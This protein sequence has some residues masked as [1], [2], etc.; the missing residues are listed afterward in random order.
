MNRTK[1]LVLA[2]FA[3]YWVFVVVLLVAARDFYDSQLPQTLRLPG[4]NQRPAEIGTLLV[5]TALFAVLSI[6]VIR[7]W[8]WTFWLILIVFLVNI[9]RVPAAALQLAGI[10]SS[11]GPAWDTVLQAV[12]GLIQF[13]I[14]LAMLAGYRKA[15]VWGAF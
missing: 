7:G 2:L 14:A 5:A 12:V 6:G 10:A 3:G 11:Q 15:G 13:A 8:R 1:V 9:V 4:N